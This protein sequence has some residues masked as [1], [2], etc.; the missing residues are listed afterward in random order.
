MPTM[1]DLPD[2]AELERLFLG[3]VLRMPT[4]DRRIILDAVLVR[5]LDVGSAAILYLVLK[6]DRIVHEMQSDLAELLAEHEG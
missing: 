1:A 6:A 5:P 2:Y 4:E 3:D